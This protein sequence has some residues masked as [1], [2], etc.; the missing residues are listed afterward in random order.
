VPDTECW[1]GSPPAF[2]QQPEQLHEAMAFGPRITGT[3][4][5]TIAPVVIGIDVSKHYL[6]LFDIARGQAEQWP[7]SCEAVEAL[8]AR[9]A[10]ADAFVVFEATGCY[11]RRLRLA[12]AAVGVRFARVNPRRARDF[13]RA[14]GFLAKTD[15]LDARML[16]A[17]GQAL[18][19]QM[20]GGSQAPADRERLALLHKRRDQLVAM[21]Q[22]ERTRLS[23]CCD[24][25][26]AGDIEQ[27]LAWL[28]TRVYAMEARIRDCIAASRELAR[29]E[30]LLRS[31]PG[32]GPVAAA[33][34][35]ACAP[36]LG[37]RSAKSM[38]ALA[39]LAPLNADSG[40]RH[41]RRRIRA[42]RKRIRDALYMAA[43]AA[44]R[45]S[46]RFGDFHRRLSAAGKPPKLA[47]IAVAR[48]LLVTANAVLRDQ[49]AFQA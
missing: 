20:R 38:A 34:L 46:T 26:I 24:A 9:F 8:A 16:A 15:R 25:E 41:G 42:G 47:L 3:G 11:D 4:I 1:L 35:L 23:E 40:L 2:G 49:V 44:V 48:K 28:D 13:A 7:N 36:E 6:D 22:Q 37:Q 21:R 12:L 32:I 27:H 39:G 33:S 10:A 5:M 43:L 17:M 29:A 45:C 18:G 19:H 14:A 30:A 31:V